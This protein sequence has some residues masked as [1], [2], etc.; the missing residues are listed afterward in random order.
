L[1][2]QWKMLV[3]FLP[4]GLFYGHLVYSVVI[5]YSLPFW[6]VVPRNIWQP[7]AGAGLFLHGNNRAAVEVG[8]LRS[9]HL[10]LQ[11][12]VHVAKAGPTDI[13]GLRDGSG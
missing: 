8:T 9:M 2:L 3:Y 12:L 1:Q 6:Y 7:W 13:E 11:N 10:M 4:L 5:L